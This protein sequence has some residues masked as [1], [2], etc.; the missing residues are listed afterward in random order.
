M[1]PRL[2]CNTTVWLL[3]FNKDKCTSVGCSHNLVSSFINLYI[4]IYVA[5]YQLCKSEL[6]CWGFIVLRARTAY[7]YPKVLQAFGICMILSRV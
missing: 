7:E 5:V 3:G 1:T 4:W 6:E 2:L